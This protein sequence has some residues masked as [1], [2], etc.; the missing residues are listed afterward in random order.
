MGRW[1]QLN[2]QI[3]SC[4]LCTR[5][6]RYCAEIA[7]TQ[8]RAFQ[9]RTYWGKPVPNF[10]DRRARLLIVGLAPAAHGGNRTGRMFTGDR[11]GDWLFRAL[12]KAGF[13]TQPGGR[14]RNDGLRLR[15]CAIT[16]SCHCAPPANKPTP[17]ELRNCRRWL[18]QT[19]DLLPVRVFL[20][21]GQIAWR[22]VL[23][24][25]RQ[26]EWIDGRSP[27]FGHGV[28]VA[29]ADGRWLVGSYHPSQRNTFTGRLTEPM[30]DHV[31][32]IARDLLV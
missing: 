5:L 22:A 10:G 32:R 29:L 31:F 12:H 6:R 13:A 28:K 15:D 3:T 24:E 26:R 2:K 21:L 18:E 7:E 17:Q 4:E 23:G 1:E 27:K 20:A 30:F 19:I 14:N 8:R 11:S 16:A 9:D 25:I